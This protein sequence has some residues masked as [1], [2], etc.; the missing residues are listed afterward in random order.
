MVPGVWVWDFSHRFWD[1][2]FSYHVRFTQSQD[3]ELF[4][5]GLQERVKEWF[6]NNSRKNNLIP[7]WRRTQE[8]I[9][10]GC[11]AWGGGNWKCPVWF[12]VLGILR[13]HFSSARSNGWYKFPKL[14]E[15][16]VQIVHTPSCLDWKPRVC[17]KPRE[18]VSMKEDVEENEKDCTA[19]RRRWKLWS[20]LSLEAKESWETTLDSMHIYLWVCMLSSPLPKFQ[21]FVFLH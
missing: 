9:R 11:G 6:R 18:V 15:E 17:F 12:E 10:W 14:G 8:W 3:K 2:L 7:T 21:P 4:D 5:N 19:G 20:P 1:H 13:R 16:W